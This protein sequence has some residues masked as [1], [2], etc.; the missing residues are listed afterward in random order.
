M[1]LLCACIQ[2]R[3]GDFLNARPHLFE[4]HN[5]FVSL[6]E[7]STDRQLQQGHTTSKPQVGDS[8]ML[9]ADCFSAVVPNDPRQDGNLLMH[10]GHLPLG[11]PCS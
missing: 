5:H 7:P 11:I 8:S 4:V 3:L 6:V 2:G 9:A 10:T 1:T